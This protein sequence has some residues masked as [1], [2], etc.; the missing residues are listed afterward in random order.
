MNKYNTNMFL[1][2][3]DAIVS[4]YNSRVN[5]TYKASPNDAFQ[6]HNYIRA[7][8]NLELHYIKALNIKEKLKYKMG[9]EVRIQ[10]STKGGGVF[11]KVINL[12]IQPKSLLYIEL[13]LG[14]L[15]QGII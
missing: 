10:I 7:M 1:D 13:I 14:Y 5:R 9:D 3:I 6:D 11:G 15:Y 4:S 12:H 8:K 2:R